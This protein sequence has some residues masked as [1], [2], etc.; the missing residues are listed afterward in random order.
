[1]LPR[2]S[3]S[4]YELS[5]IEPTKSQTGRLPN[6]ISVREGEILQETRAR[7]YELLRQSQKT[8]APNM[9]YN[10]F[11]EFTFKHN[12]KR[13]DKRGKKKA[14]GHIYSEQKSEWSWPLTHLS[15]LERVRGLSI[16]LEVAMKRGQRQ[17]HYHQRRAQ[18]VGRTRNVSSLR[19][20]DDGPPR[21]SEERETWAGSGELMS[22]VF[23]AHGSSKRSI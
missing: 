15:I 16:A 20:I 9:R 18:V 22:A 17:L 21:N 7:A 19:L 12:K 6:K 4:T 3:A 5:R 10:S 14:K 8:K 11:Q 2:I 23:F 1:M 13:S